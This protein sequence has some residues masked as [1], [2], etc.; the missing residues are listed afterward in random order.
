MP[1]NALPGQVGFSTNKYGK[2]SYQALAAGLV[3]VRRPHMKHDTAV[4]G[5]AG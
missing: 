2:A 5:Q 4:G 1:I 3:L